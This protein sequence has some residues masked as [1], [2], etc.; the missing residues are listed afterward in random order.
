MS[1]YR[2]DTGTLR[3]AQYRGDGSMVVEAHITRAGVLKYRNPDGTERLEYRPPE[4]VFKTDSLES[5]ALVPVTDEHPP[6]MLTTRTVKKYAAGTTGENVR[7]DG[8]HVAARLV[9]TDDALIAKMKAGKREVSCGYA[10]DIDE[11][12]GVT[13]DGI[14]YDAVQRNI[15]GNHLA[16]TTHGRVGSAR[17][18]MD[19]VLAEITEDD[20]MAD[21]RTDAFPPKKKASPAAAP[22]AAAPPADPA[23]APPAPPADPEAPEDEVEET[24]VDPAAPPAGPA[25]SPA[26]GASIEARLASTLGQ[27]AQ[28]IQELTDAKAATATA[29]ARADAAE[30][31]IDERVR[32]RVDLETVAR[33]VLGAAIRLDGLS[34]REVQL[35]VIEEVTGVVVPESKSNDYVTARYDAAL[36]RYEAAGL[37]N[38]KL[39]EV[40]AMRRDTAPTPTDRDADEAAAARAE[41]IARNRGKAAAK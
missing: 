28:L 6:K 26:G 25:S 4:E 15:R 7:Q 27:V 5:F 16:V 37:A 24:E 13:P 8:D 40:L 9:I 32:A 19:S 17:V 33:P 20:S 35:L 30:Q 18:R 41:M 1:S 12:P 34:D 23:A 11:T 22:A 3:K 38:A 2:Y 36:E 14:R 21:T 29:T 31:A 39:T 10:C